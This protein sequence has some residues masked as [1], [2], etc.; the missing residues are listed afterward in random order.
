M[1]CHLEIMAVID[2][3]EVA[4][5]LRAMP[6]RDARAWVIGILEN[7]DSDLYHTAAEFTKNNPDNTA[8][9]Q[10]CHRWTNNI[11]LRMAEPANCD[12]CKA[13]LP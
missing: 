7:I 9:C 5:A 4:L 3:G 1:T 2:A 8:E 11:K 6:A 10:R 12:H 13:I